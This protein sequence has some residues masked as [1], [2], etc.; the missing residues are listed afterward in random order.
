[1]EGNTDRFR[2]WNVNG[3]MFG[4]LLTQVA[5]VNTLMSTQWLDKCLKMDGWLRVFPEC[6]PLFIFC[7]A[8]QWRR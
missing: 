6:F 3:T 4:E 7:S 5:P 8:D 2:Q 1:M